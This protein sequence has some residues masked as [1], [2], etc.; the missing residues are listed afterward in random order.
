MKYAKWI[1]IDAVLICV[2]V[3]VWYWYAENHIQP[4]SVI[5][6]EAIEEVLPIKPRIII[7]EEP[8]RPSFPEHWGPEPQIQTKDYRKLPEPFGMGSSTLYNW[9]KKNQ[10]NDDNPASLRPIGED[11][12]TLE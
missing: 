4:L 5:E 10:Y 9:I 11:T 7:C 3:A 2:L 8:P 6:E 1:I 12:P